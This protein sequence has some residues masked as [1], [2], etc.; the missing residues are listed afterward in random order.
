MSVK[1]YN[2]KLTRRTPP[3]AMESQRQSRYRE[4]KK[5]SKE[6]TILNN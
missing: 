6:L 5:L 4:K 2:K 1:D 3:I